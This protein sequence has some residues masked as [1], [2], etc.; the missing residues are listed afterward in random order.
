MTQPLVEI[1]ELSGNQIK[2][3]KI[4]EQSFYNPTEAARLMEITGVTVRNWIKGDKIRGYYKDPQ[5]GRCYV[6]EEFIKNQNERKMK[7][8]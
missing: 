8:I 4:G 1:V 7:K 6:P 5:N 2:I 3:L